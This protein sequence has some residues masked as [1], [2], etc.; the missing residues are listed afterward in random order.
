MC[1]SIN[2]VISFTLAGFLLGLAIPIALLISAVW[3]AKI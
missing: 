3:N 2:L 1:Y